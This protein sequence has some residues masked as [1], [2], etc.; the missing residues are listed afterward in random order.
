MVI[1]MFT[2][3]RRMNEDRKMCRE[4]RG[5]IRNCQKEVTELK[6]TVTA[7]KIHYRGSTADEIKQ[8]R[9]AL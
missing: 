8:N 2:E 5:N 3:L 7:A 4:E 9:S 1:K 6:S